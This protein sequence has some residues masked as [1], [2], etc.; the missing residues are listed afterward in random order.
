MNKI[1]LSKK[2]LAALTFMV[3]FGD[4]FA[5]GNTWKLNGNNN[6]NSNDFIGSKNYE[7]F[8]IKTDNH[9]CKNTNYRSN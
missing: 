4:T 6:V 9:Y 8:N 2:L 1:Y 5:Q 3:M 7:D